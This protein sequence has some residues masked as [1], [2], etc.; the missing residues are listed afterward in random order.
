MRFKQKKKKALII[1]SICRSVSTSRH[2]TAKTESRRDGEEADGSIHSGQ[3]GVTFPLHE[4][5]LPNRPW[6]LLLG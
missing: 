1:V 4:S 6:E 2:R 3:L 5:L